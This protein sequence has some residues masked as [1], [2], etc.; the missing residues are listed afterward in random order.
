MVMTKRPRKRTKTA[1]RQS[2]PTPS[3]LTP[4]QQRFVAEYLIDLN[5]TQAAIR[6]GY[7]A[8]TAE[9]QASRL[10]RN[11]KVAEAVA[12]ATAKRLEKLDLTADRVLAEMVRLGFSDVRKLF[13]EDGAFKS[14]KDW[15]DETAAAVAGVD[16]VE[17]AGGA[18][19]G[20]KEG[21]QH[22]PMY[23][24]KVKLWDKKGAL[25]LLAKHLGLLKEKVEHS[26]SLLISWQGDE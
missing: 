20:G 10:L 6:S 4:K 3:A 17:M 23:T 16:V 14:P 8:K 11:V 7:S 5:A 24:K 9:F 21:V 18:K 25:E 15:D 13:R 2:S 12:T 19:I 1:A 22:V 26:G